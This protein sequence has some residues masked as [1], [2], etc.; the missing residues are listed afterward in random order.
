MI[1]FVGLIRYTDLFL[2]PRGKYFGMLASMI[3]KSLY[4]LGRASNPLWVRLAALVVVFILGTAACAVLFFGLILALQA[5]GAAG[6]GSVALLLLLTV[7]IVACVW[8]A[9]KITRVILDAKISGGLPPSS[10]NIIQK[11]S[12]PEQQTPFPPQSSQYRP[13]RFSLA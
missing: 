11:R 3:R 8:A 1:F 7:G 9:P 2:L 4:E 12:S 5:A 6:L 10:G 13:P